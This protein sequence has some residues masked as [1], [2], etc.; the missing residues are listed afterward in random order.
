MPTE[1]SLKGKVIE[2]SSGLLQKIATKKM[3]NQ[4]K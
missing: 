4:M 1:G 2:A 3:K